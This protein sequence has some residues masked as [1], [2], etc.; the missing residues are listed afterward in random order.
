MQAQRVKEALDSKISQDFF[1]SSINLEESHLEE[2]YREGFS[3]GLDLGQKEG[4]EVGL[5]VGFEFGEEIGFYRGCVDVWSAAI[6]IDAKRF[7]PNIQR[8]VK[9][10]DKLIKL[11]PVLDPENETA[12][13]IMES[14]RAKFKAISA[15]FAVSLTSHGKLEYTGL[16]K[17]SGASNVDF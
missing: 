1:D 4:R 2:G 11:Y 12:H 7:T 15:S 8:I 9:Q 5:K 17:F 10:M 3:D 16:A 14:L 6:Q 13:D